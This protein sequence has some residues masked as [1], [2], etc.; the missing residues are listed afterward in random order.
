MVSLVWSV[1]HLDHFN[2]PPV[3][4]LLSKQRINSSRLFSHFPRKLVRQ[5]WPTVSR[6]CPG[7]RISGG[8]D[9][10]K[11]RS[12]ASRP[13]P[14]PAPYS[15]HSRTGGV[16]LCGGPGS[17]PAQL[18]EIL[19]TWLGQPGPPGAANTL[20]R[21]PLGHH[22]DIS[23]ENMAP[24][25]IPASRPTAPSTRHSILE[26][27]IATSHPAPVM[28]YKLYGCSGSRRRLKSVQEAVVIRTVNTVVGAGVET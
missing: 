27:Q 8:L 18:H 6:G 4:R 14:L 22:W 26:F 17:V 10:M 5:P 7:G 19:D 3:S 13:S 24:T 12:G 15:P 21:P 16:E 28:Y 23:S 11:E 2:S 20:Q 1:S 9:L 25:A